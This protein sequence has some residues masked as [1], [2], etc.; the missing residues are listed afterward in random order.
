ML[1]YSSLERRGRLDLRI[2]SVL[3]IINPTGITHVGAHLAE[4]AWEYEFFDLPCTW[5][6]AAPEL[7]DLIQI[8]GL[9]KNQSVVQRLLGGTAGKIQTLNFYGP[10][11]AL[12]SVLEVRD[13]ENVAKQLNLETSTLDELPA[14]DLL[15]L[16]VQGAELEVLRGGG[17]FLKSC[18]Y[19]FL[20]VSLSDIYYHA[21][22]TLVDISKFLNFSGFEIALKVLHGHSGNEGNCL[23]VNKSK[24]GRRERIDLYIYNIYRYFLLRYRNTRR[25]ARKFLHIRH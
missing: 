1:K 6:E 23:F 3:N 9:P 20:E 18:K 11:G 25:D 21:T 24:I 16:D 15:V 4:E 22:P 5:V 14:S 12:S 7:V 13:K 8:T 17:E 19:I 2:G 10:E